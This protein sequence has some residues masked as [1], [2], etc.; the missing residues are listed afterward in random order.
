MRFFR[1]FTVATLALFLVG[2]LLFNVKL[3]YQ[4]SYQEVGAQHIN[5]GVLRQLA[6][7]KEELRHGAGREMQR[8]YPEGFVFLNALYGLSWLEVS[9]YLTS[10]S[11]LYQEAHEEINWVLK[12]VLSEKAKSNFSA[13]LNP[14]YGIFYRG[15]SNYLLGTKLRQLSKAH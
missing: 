15:W 14:S 3:Y 4:P 1:L 13:R 2:V 8:I 12:E 11:D 7:L 9:E 6:H 10:E 5:K